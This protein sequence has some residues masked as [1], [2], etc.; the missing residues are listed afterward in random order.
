MSVAEAPA[1]EA[2][3]WSPTRLDRGERIRAVVI[4]VLLALVLVALPERMSAYW[5]SVVT[6]VARHRSRSSRILAGGPT[7]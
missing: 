7:R 1:R 2:P 3:A 5:T 6:Q 4:V